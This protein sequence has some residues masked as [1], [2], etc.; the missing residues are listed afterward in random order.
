MT[1]DWYH[2]VM[3][4]SDVFPVILS[5][6]FAASIASSTTWAQSRRPRSSGN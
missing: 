6:R 2:S 1:A 4:C 3:M 5:T